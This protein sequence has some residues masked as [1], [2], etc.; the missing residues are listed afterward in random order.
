MSAASIDLL[1]ILNIVTITS[2]INGPEGCSM[3]SINGRNTQFESITV[4]LYTQSNRGTTA[5]FQDVYTYSSSKTAV[6]IVF[7]VSH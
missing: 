3:Y 7:Q 1:L 2:Y 4:K 5:S 6:G